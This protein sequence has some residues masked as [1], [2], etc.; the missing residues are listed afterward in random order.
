MHQGQEELVPELEALPQSGETDDQNAE[1]DR[2]A[3]TGQD[4]EAWRASKEPVAGPVPGLASR[5]RGQRMVKPGQARP[6]ALSAEQRL[7]LLDTWRRSGLPAGDFAALVGLSKHTLYAWKKK[8]D[9]KGPAGLMDQP[10]GGLPGSRLPDLTKRAILM[11]KQSNP[12]W[13]CERIS[14]MLLRGPALPASAGAVARV[15]R[16]AGYETEEVVVHPHPAH[17]R[18]FER[19]RPNQLW[20]TDLFTFVLKRQNRRVYLVAFLDDHSRYIVGYGLHASQSTALVLEVL[21]AALS[22][23]GTPEEILTDNGSQYVT[24]RGKSAFS[25]ELEKRGIKQV[26]ATPRR[27]QTLGKI[28]RFWGTLWRECVESAVFVDLGDAQRRIGLFI[29]HYCC[30]S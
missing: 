9:T 5:R 16:E 8:F 15:L 21:R 6:P 20:Q 19:A 18:Y 4:G 24:W 13:G 23:Y 27:P 1:T 3:Q 10:R 11:L 7:L 22:S 14:D 29:D 17:V 12:E 2:D 25:R 28:E 30:A 26:V